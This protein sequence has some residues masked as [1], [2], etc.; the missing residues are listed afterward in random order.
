MALWKTIEFGYEKFVKPRTDTA[1]AIKEISE[2][3][4]AIKRDISEMKDKQ[5]ND[6]ATL[7]AHAERLHK[8]EERQDDFRD[9]LSIS[10]DA[11]RALI[12]H[13]VDGNNTEAMKKS[14][15]DIDNYLKKHL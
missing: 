8:L 5:A 3:M 14:L 15:T 7:H 9:Y 6:Y 13:A 2:D 1:K 11:M 10:L 12:E 4:E